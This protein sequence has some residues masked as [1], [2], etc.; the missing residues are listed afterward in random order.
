VKVSNARGWRRIGIVISLVWF[1]GFGVWLWTATAEEQARPYKEGLKHCG[2]MLDIANDG[3]QYLPVGP[4]R[5]KQQSDNFADYLKC[6][7]D[8][9]VRWTSNRSEMKTQI[10]VVLGADIA[11]IALAW[12]VV[13][14]ITVLVRW[15]ARGFA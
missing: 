14:L 6:R 5:D 10:A 1:L 7:E 9:S 11:S 4:A 8:E 15:V 12:L 2:R 13:W 3:L